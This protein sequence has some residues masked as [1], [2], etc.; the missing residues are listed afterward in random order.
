VLQQQKQNRE[1]EAESPYGA[2]PNR[3]LIVRYCISEEC[4]CTVFLKQQA[5]EYRIL[6]SPKK[7]NPR[8]LASSW[9]HVKLS[10]LVYTLHCWMHGY[11]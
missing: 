9:K 10:C 1:A 4:C 2:V 8:L 6:W 3:A 11:T 7:L 5:H